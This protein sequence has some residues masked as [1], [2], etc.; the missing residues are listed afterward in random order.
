MKNQNEALEPYRIFFPLGLFLALFAVF[1]WLMF[2]VGIL[3]FYPRDAHAQLMYFGFFWSFVAGFL[4]TAI[5]KMTGTLPANYLEQSIGVFLAFLQLI[6]TLRNQ[7]QLS[8]YIYLVQIV[9]LIIFTI[10]RF[11][12]VKKIPFE[13]F[14]FI[15]FAFLTSILGM[16]LS[17]INYLN[18]SQ[19]YKISAELFLLNLIF[20]LGA[21]LIPAISRFANALKPDQ[22]V[23]LSKIKLFSFSSLLLNTTFIF[24]VL[25]NTI[26][27][28]M[29]IMI[30]IIFYVIFILGFFK[31]PT[32]WSKLSIG[33]KFGLFFLM[34]GYVVKFAAPNHYPIAVSHFVYIGG[35][36][37]ITLMIAT[38][39]KLAHG[40]IDL[41]YEIT[42]KRS[43]Y[44]IVLIALAAI[45]RVG[46]HAA[47]EGVFIN[48]SLIL[49]ICALLLWLH[50]FY[51]IEKN[52]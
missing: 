40:G 15:P 43:L 32:Q 41:N 27:T 9:F 34:L 51:E 46:A 6:L 7:I 11:I 18:P 4:M 49:F 31:K 3:K 35:L 50:K 5:P 10:K 13:G 16:Y 33:L 48:L 17:W 24:D 23:S 30:V 47:I 42:S 21:R 52:R 22:V 39:V 29:L 36:M 25:V 45:T 2:N 44:I 37:L 12:Y 1:Y 8:K 28:R 19:F 20:G 26:L 14:I 38:R